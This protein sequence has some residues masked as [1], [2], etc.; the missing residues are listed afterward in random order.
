MSQTQ[1][2]VTGL[3]S[4]VGAALAAYAVAHGIPITPDQGAAVVASAAGAGAAIVG[5]AAHFITAWWQKRHAPQ[6][7]PN[8]AP[9]AVVAA[10]VPSA[11]PVATASVPT[12]PET[13]R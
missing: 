12:T 4:I 3:S 8:P 2:A 7:L 13:T 5:G 6:V 9:A 11:P 1:S 10:P